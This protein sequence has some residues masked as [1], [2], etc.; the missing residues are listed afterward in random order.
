MWSYKFLAVVFALGYGASFLVNCAIL[1]D[2]IQSCV[3][4][5]VI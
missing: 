4:L 3:Y 2:R 1:K 5:K